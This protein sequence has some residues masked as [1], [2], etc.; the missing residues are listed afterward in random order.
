MR[1]GI[2][3]GPDIYKDPQPLRT[4]KPKLFAVLLAALFTAGLTHAAQ[5]N[6]IQDGPDGVDPLG[7]VRM[8]VSAEGGVTFTPAPGG[9]APNLQINPGGEQLQPPPADPQVR[10]CVPEELTPCRESCWAMG[11]QTLSCTV[12]ADSTGKMTLWCRCGYIS[13]RT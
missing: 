11:Q 5:Q 4:G 2:Q 3:E 13:L 7:V 8:H 10:R 6:G 1:D 12:G 9:L